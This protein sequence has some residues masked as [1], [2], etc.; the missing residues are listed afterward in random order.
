[1]TDETSMGAATVWYT[2]GCHKERRRK[3]P[4]KLDW[5]PS[6]VGRVLYERKTVLEGMAGKDAIV[7]VSLLDNHYLVWISLGAHNGESS[8]EYGI[9]SLDDSPIGIPLL[10]TKYQGRALFAFMRVEAL[11]G[12]LD[13]V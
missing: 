7:R 13:I 6:T 12:E 9:W 8:K 11:I 3:R 4:P 5:M 10:L 1:M 2:G